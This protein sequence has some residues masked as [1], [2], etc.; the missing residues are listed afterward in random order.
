MVITYVCMPRVA[1]LIVSDKACV[2]YYVSS[3]V[4]KIYTVKF[5]AFDCFIKIAIA[6]Y[7]CSF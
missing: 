3:Y 6:T 4:Y 5:I 2:V 7:G 1:E